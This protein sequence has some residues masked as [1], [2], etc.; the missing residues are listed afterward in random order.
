MHNPVNYWH[1]LLQTI[2]AQGSV[3][4]LRHNLPLWF[5]TCLFSVEI[6]F[7]F[8]NKLLS[9]HYSFIVCV[10]CSILGCYITNRGGVDNE[11]TMEF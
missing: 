4:F 7:Y 1:P 2:I 5:V 9:M 6:I 10:L 11:L 8:I 3:G